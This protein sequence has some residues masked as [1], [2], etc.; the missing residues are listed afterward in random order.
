M[1][2]CTPWILMRYY[3][4]VFYVS[5]RLSRFT[6]ILTKTIKSIGQAKTYAELAGNATY[7]SFTDPTVVDLYISR[8]SSELDL[9][10]TWFEWLDT[11]G[12]LLMSA[13]GQANILR[14]LYCIV[15]CLMFI[16]RSILYRRIVSEKIRYIFKN[17][18]VTKT[19]FRII[20]I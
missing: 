11:C 20:L 4:Y 14:S 18:F 13:F 2:I 8:I 9:Y 1:R 17:F 6:Q 3:V 5:I 16:V 7:Y 12:L 15:G 19:S 10:S